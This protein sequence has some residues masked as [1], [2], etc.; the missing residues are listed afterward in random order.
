MSTVRVVTPR[1]GL[2]VYYRCR[3][4][5]GSQKLA[6]VPDPEK[7]GRK[8]KAVIE[9]KGEAGYCLATPSPPECHKTG[10]RYVYEGGTLADVPVITTWRGSVDALWE[11]TYLP[12][13]LRPADGMPLIHR[14]QGRAHHC[15]TP[16]RPSPFHTSGLTS[17]YPLAFPVAL[18][19]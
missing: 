6:R 12:L 8:P 3:T 4:F 18:A 1:P 2:H 17:A 16:T 13:N 7:G 15:C 14:A 19:S 9:L 5:G 10:R 11:R